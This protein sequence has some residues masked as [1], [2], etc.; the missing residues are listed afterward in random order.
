MV[1][2]PVGSGKTTLLRALLGLVGTDAGTIRWNG[3]AVADPS[4]VL[5]PPRAAYLPQVP[6]LFSEP[7][8]DTVL[9]GVPGRRPRPRAVADVPRRGPGLDARRRRDGD[10]PGGLRLSGGQIQRAGAARAL[11][12]RP[13]LLVV[14]DLSSALDVD[15]EA[16]LWDRVA[17]GGFATA[18]L[19]SHRP[20]VL[21]RADRVVVLDAGRVVEVA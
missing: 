13:E 7:L 2:G 12:R 16:R 19:V 17:D 11:V 15:T 20:H 14:D 5:V 3:A 9:L 10:R 18:L 4:T 1:T 8:A 21:E 6:R